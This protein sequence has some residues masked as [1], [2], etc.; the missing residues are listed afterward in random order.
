MVYSKT[1]KKNELDNLA[2]EMT[3]LMNQVETIIDADE[4]ADVDSYIDRI[5]TILSL[6]EIFAPQLIDSRM[7][8]RT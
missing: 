2:I 6:L 3:S 8:Q 7:T 5:S 4:L 1:M